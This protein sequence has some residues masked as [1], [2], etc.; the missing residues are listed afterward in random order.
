M[1]FHYLVSI[2]HRLLR[3]V[4]RICFGVNNVHSIYRLWWNDGCRNPILQEPWS[5]IY[6][7]NHGLYQCVIGTG[8][9][10]FLQVRVVDKIKEQIRNQS[11]M[12]GL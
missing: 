11:L 1:H 6:A 4:R 3:D 12:N 7:H 10:R 2:H 8:S 9:V 5:A